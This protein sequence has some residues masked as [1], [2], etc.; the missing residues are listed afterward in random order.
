MLSKNDHFLCFHGPEV[1]NIVNE[2]H[3][4]YCKVREG[5]LA[6]EAGDKDS[7]LASVLNSHVSMH[8]T[9]SGSGSHFSV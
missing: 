3:P 7:T 9:A 6:W 4:Y 5:M 1:W 8:I 2:F